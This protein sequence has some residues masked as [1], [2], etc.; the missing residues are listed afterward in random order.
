MICGD[1]TKLII[2]P[3]ARVPPRELLPSSSMTY[4]FHS[5]PGLIP[6]KLLSS[7]EVEEA[8]G[9][10]GKVF[11]SDVC[12]LEV[13]EQG[14]PVRERGSGSVFKEQLNVVY[15]V[16]SSRVTGD[17]DLVVIRPHEQNI[18]IAPVADAFKP[19]RV[20]LTC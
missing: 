14:G 5:P 9:A 3:P 20:T 16:C 7:A 2:Q 19:S 1:V 8:A 6:A 18:G 13:P 4:S 17:D 15:G 11:R 10:P 12:R